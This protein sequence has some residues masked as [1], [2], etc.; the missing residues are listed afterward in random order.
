MEL[1]L[2]EYPQWDV[3]GPH[4][5]FI[6]QRMFVHAA[7]S[8]QKEAERLIC[9]SHWHG[10]PGL[11]PEADLSAVQLVGYPTSREEIGDLFHQV[12]MLKRLPKPPPCGPEWVWEVTRDIL[13]SLRECLRWRRGEQSGGSGELE[14]ASA[15]PSCH[16]DRA[17]QR[18]RQDTLGEQEL[19]EARVAHWQV[20]VA[21]SILEEQI[22]RLSQSTTR[23]R[24]DVCHHSQSQDQPRRRS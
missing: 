21:A 11:D 7:E 15:C 1:F 18:E 20:L 22:E 4:H 16:W 13:Y 9:H 17:S 8:G 23:M 6:L 3:R 14:P 24:P 5:P 19:T 12:Y 10:L 2:K